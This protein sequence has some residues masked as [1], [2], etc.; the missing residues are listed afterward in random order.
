MRYIASREGGRLTAGTVVIDIG[1]THAKVSLWDEQGRLLSRRMR[2]NER[3]LAA[4]RSDNRSPYA[5][6][7]LDVEG[8]DPWLMDS[9][10]ACAREAH[11]VRIV[12]VGHG[13]AAALL[14]DGRLFA[15]PMDYEEP[16]GEAERNAYAAQR[17][18][19]SA[20]GSPFLPCALN[21]GMQLHRLESLHGPLPAGVQILPWPQY[22][23][24]RLCGVMASEVTSLGCHS[25]L[26]RPA[27]RRFSD[28]AVRRGWAARVAPLRQAGETLSTIRPEVAEATRLPPDC[29]V[30]CGVHDSNAALLA[31]RGRPEIAGRDATVLS[32]GTW[33]VAMRSLGPGT[34]FD[35]ERLPEFRDCLV[36]VDVRGRA[37]PSARFMGGRE[38]EIICGGDV[39]PLSD[40]MH[41][42]VLR[43]IPDVLARGLRAY[44]S[45]VAGVGPFPHVSGCTEH[46][47]GDPLD[48]RIISSLY[49]AMMTDASL[50]LIDSDGPLLVEGRFA[51][52]NVF[53]RALAELRPRQ[54]VYTSAAQDDLA[55]GALRL[56]AT[57]FA[58]PS[59]LVPVEPL[60][61]DVRAFAEDWRRRAQAD[62]V[63][64]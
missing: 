34:D 45:F 43:R 62:G 59:R 35:T 15:D 42:E 48:R 22:W 1:K 9:L 39:P 30:L 36:N 8:I 44:P 2:A 52:D 58:T 10:A 60:G 51:D 5:Y 46:L 12:P 24:W 29:A 20:S 7:A 56:A 25:D 47:T 61:I 37:V 38:A 53:V 54:R 23:A 40:A 6:R 16:I 49:L 63:H 50:S 31:L 55:Y 21:L 19:F 3:R 41:V 57:D 13:A 4:G 33:F 26:W 11:V 27:E 18:A 17:D 14:R 28:L 32:T 64:A